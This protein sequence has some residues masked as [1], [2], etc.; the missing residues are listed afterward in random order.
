MSI[1]VLPFHK[2]KRERTILIYSVYFIFENLH[3]GAYWDTMDRASPTIRTF[4]ALAAVMKMMIC[5]MQ[6]NRMS[7][8]DKCNGCL[9]CIGYASIT[10]WISSPVNRC[11]QSVKFDSWASWCTIT[12]SDNHI[13]LPISA[14]RSH[15]LSLSPCLSLFLSSCL[16]LPCSLYLSLSEQCFS[17]AVMMCA[18]HVIYSISGDRKPKSESKNRCKWM[19]EEEEGA[20]GDE[21]HTP[22]K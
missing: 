7:R 8:L 1:E 16:F 21:I 20:A 22:V 4:A 19:S 6:L 17:C 14:L 18:V 5:T 11:N 12:E 10:E 15:P 2:M 3:L 13:S 9:R